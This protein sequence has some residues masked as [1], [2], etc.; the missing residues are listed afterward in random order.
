[1]GRRLASTLGPPV[2][3]D[4]RNSLVPLKTLKNLLRRSAIAILQ[5]R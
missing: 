3:V 2:L 5:A 4:F 1:M